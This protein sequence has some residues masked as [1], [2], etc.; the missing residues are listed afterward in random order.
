MILYNLLYTINLEN[1]SIEHRGFLLIQCIKING[2]N[3]HQVSRS[4]YAHF[5]IYFKLY[6]CKQD[7]RFSYRVNYILNVPYIHKW[8]L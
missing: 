2:L 4:F 8:Y 5:Q 1:G 7:S 6:Q 3:S